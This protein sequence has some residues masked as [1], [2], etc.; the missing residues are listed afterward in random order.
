MKLNTLIRTLTRIQQFADEEGALSVD[1]SPIEDEWGP[2]GYCIVIEL[3]SW[4]QKEKRPHQI[5]TESCE[6][7]GRFNAKLIP[8]ESVQAS[9]NCLDIFI[10]HSEE[11]L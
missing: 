10:L 9:C 6:A 5:Y 2:S 3:Q 8:V 1:I 11:E 4:N 7:V